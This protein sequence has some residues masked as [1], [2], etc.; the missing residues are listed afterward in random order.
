MQAWVA[1]LCYWNMACVCVS[2]SLPVCV[3]ITSSVYPVSW[4]IKHSKWNV[5]GEKKME[6]CKKKILP[7]RLNGRTR[8]ATFTLSEPLFELTGGKVWNSV[9]VFFFFFFLVFALLNWFVCY[10][11]QLLFCLNPILCVRTGPGI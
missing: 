3:A 10:D 8:I 2:V 5:N 4:V 9:I 1:A 7:R 6:Y 11:Q